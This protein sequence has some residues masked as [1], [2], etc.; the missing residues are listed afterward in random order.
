MTIPALTEI[1][2][3]LPRVRGGGGSAALDQEALFRAGLDHVQ[4]LSRRIWTDYNVHDPGITTLELLCFAI[5]DLAYR[6]SLPVED[7]LTPE[8][9]GGAGLRAQFFGA[10]RILPNRPV[11]LID[12]RKLLIDSADIRNAWILPAPLTFFADRAIGKLLHEDPGTPGV[13]AD[14]GHGL[15]RVLVELDDPELSPAARQAVLDDAMRKLQANRNLCEDFVSV[16]AIETERYIVCGDID[17]TSN[18]DVARVKAEILHRL[19]SH[20][21]PR[22]RNYTLSEML[23][24]PNRDG[25]RYTA[26]EIFDGP[27][28]DHGFIDALDLEAAELRT[29]IR[30]SDIISIIMDIPGVEAV[31]DLVVNVLGADDSPAAPADKWSVAVTP[32]RQPVLDRPRC[33]LLLRKR[34][35]PVNAR[36]T[37]VDAIYQQLVA[38]ERAWDAKEPGDIPLPAGRYHDLAR[39]YSVQNHFPAAYGLAEGGPTGAPNDK[40]A[41]RVRLSAYQLKGYLLFFDHLMAAY[42]AQLAHVRD[43]YSWD[44]PAAEA[45]VR[46]YFSQTVTTFRDSD[47]LY[48]D[49]DDE[50]L[51]D[52]FE[53]DAEAVSRRNRFLDHLIG[54]FAEQFSEYAAVAHSVLSASPREQLRLKREFLAVYPELGAERG[55]GVD[56]FA[57]GA[58]VWDTPAVSGLEHRVARMVGLRN[59]TRRDLSDVA[60]DDDAFLDGSDADGFL[61]KLRLDAQRL[62]FIGTTKLATREAAS[63]ALREAVH[64]AQIPA[65]LELKQAADDRFFFNVVDATGGTLARHPSFYNTEA[66]ADA[67]IDAVIETVS[68]RYGEEGMYL[69]ENLSLRP[70]AGKDA[71]LLPICVDP[72]CDDC[73][74]E[75]PYSYRIRVVLPA[76]AGRFTLMEFRRFVDSVIREETPAHI[77]PTVCWI[78]RDDMGRLEQ[79]YRDWLELSADAGAEDRSAA[80]IALRDVLYAVK[81]VYP[82]GALEDCK[83]DA[84]NPQ[85][86]RLGQTALGTIPR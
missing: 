81:N 36:S 68:R 12:Y 76:F 79:V 42:C 85:P 66:E 82:A 14:G 45:R 46:S 10:R 55:L 52:L 51:S 59:W 72:N 30:L 22:V 37:Q 65:R 5:T 23:E 17:L 53:T 20:L 54:R 33:R 32:G 63:A 31:R 2:P 78:G 26:D 77:L 8:T 25:V 64:A 1:G 15:Y 7:L 84:E 80:L 73:A 28:L 9:D 69:I 62:A 49:V 56:H 75:D 60:L 6:A 48:R 34:D 21:T 38:E 57:A 11:T 67:A 41:L 18:A 27:A 61:F 71:E 40:D 86:F 4:Q 83:S 19:Q 39:Y 43:L 3:V 47:R 50:D 58:P 24:R 35:I 16:E 70:A 44:E 29:E 13:H 74:D